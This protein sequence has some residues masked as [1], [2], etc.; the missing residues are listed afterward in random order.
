M[1]RGLQMLILATMPVATVAQGQTAKR[2]RGDHENDDGRVQ[3]PLLK[4]N[5]MR[6]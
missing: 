3:Q 2:Q 5:D 6:T 1:F 4:R